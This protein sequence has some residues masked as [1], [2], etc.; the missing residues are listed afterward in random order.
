MFGS[1][2]EVMDSLSTLLDYEIDMFKN[3]DFLKILELK[4]MVKS[5]IYEDT[6]SELEILSTK[7]DRILENISCS[8][9]LL[10]ECLGEII[11]EVPDR[12]IQKSQEGLDLALV[13]EGVSESA[14]SLEMSEVTG[15]MNNLIE[16]KAAELKFNTYS[17]S[18][19]SVDGQLSINVEKQGDIFEQS[20]ENRMDLFRL[21]DLHNSRINE[22][23]E[24]KR[25]ALMEEE[26]KM[27][28]QSKFLT[29]ELI[30]LDMKID[31]LCD[32]SDETE[33]L[34]IMDGLDLDDEEKKEFLE[35]YKR[36]KDQ[37]ILETVDSAL[38]NVDE[39]EAYIEQMAKMSQGENVEDF[40]PNSVTIAELMELTDDAFEQEEFNDDLD[41]QV[42]L[43]FGF[44]EKILGMVSTP[45]LTSY[46]VQAKI[47]YNFG[48]TDYLKQL[49]EIIDGILES[50][51]DYI[52]PSDEVYDVEFGQGLPEKMMDNFFAL[53]KLSHLIY[54][55]HE[56]LCE[57]H[58][59]GLK[60]SEEY[61]SC[62][63]H[64]EQYLEFEK[65]YLD[66]MYI[67][68]DTAEI[69]IDML[70]NSLD[71]IVT[72]GMVLDDSG[73]TSVSDEEKFALKTRLQDLMPVLKGEK[74]DI[75]TSQQV[76]YSIELAHAQRVF[77]AFYN[78]IESGI[79]ADL[80]QQL[81]REMYKQS[82]YNSCITMDMVGSSFNPNDITV[83]DDELSSTLLNVSLREYG[84]DKDL[85]L[86]SMAFLL[87]DYINDNLDDRARILFNVIRLQELLKDISFESV[88]GLQHRYQD[89]TNQKGN[90]E[91][92]LKLMPLFKS[93]LPDYMGEE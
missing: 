32:F 33:V 15:R 73:V 27:I 34:Q 56:E 5:S 6:L 88:Y 66:K 57:L 58:L 17:I 1:K 93:V 85:R 71:L 52:K 69:Y 92:T 62:L 91:K 23:D 49:I 24:T 22:A 36:R 79:D 45:A 77:K 67:F 83:M 13:G 2:V 72:D 40:D 76:I 18:C 21:L 63:R 60:D 70:E 55:K 74:T 28:Y 48:Q 41:A 14:L 68:E 11:Q 50:R 43:D 54:M 65:S 31:L 46:Q 39:I 86:Y 4:G 8:S 75:D 42:I 61:K 59:K 37:K 29:D 30:R 3:L 9:D 89:I 38:D 25:R 84:Y 87:L 82:F 35:E 20:L 64:L 26:F 16:V 90:S 19:Y 10:Y 80:N 81:I 78:Y 7:E 12:V 44:L 51:E 53:I 47:D